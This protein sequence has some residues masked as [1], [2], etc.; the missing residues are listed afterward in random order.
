M[1]LVRV[2][3]RRAGCLGHRGVIAV[4]VRAQ[5]VG[6]NSGVERDLGHLETEVRA[7]AHVH[8]QAHIHRLAD[9][10]VNLALAVDESTRVLGEGVGQHVAGLQQPNHLVEN[11]VG[12]HAVGTRFR[13]RPE[14]SEMDVQRQVGLLG[15]LRRHAHH[16]DAPTRKPAQFRVR[17]EALDDVRILLGGLHRGVDVQAVGLVERG[18]VMSLHAADQVGRQIGHHA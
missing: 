2:A 5:G 15:N 9:D 4:H 17:L 1:L 12:V 16:L 8:L 3:V 18:I 11:G 6:P 14:L 13:Q 7:V 10:I